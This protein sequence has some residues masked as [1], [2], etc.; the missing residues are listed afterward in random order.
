[1][2]EQMVK[3]Y[4]AELLGGLTT[5]GEG[6]SDYLQKLNHLSCIVSAALMKYSKDDGKLPDLRNRLHMA[7]MMVYSP[8]GV[9]TAWVEASKIQEELTHIIFSRDLVDYSALYDFQVKL[10][11]KWRKRGGGVGSES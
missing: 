10:N 8:K 11:E 1:M 5:L 9:S 3:R 7:M 2:T 4:I 6:I